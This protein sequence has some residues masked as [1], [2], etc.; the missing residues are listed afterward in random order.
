MRIRIRFGGGKRAVGDKSVELCHRSYC[1]D[2]RNVAG[3][4]AV[5]VAGYAKLLMY[6]GTG[7]GKM[8]AL[9]M[10]SRSYSLGVSGV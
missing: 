6:L 10:L 4:C 5:H 7:T 3:W 2:R 8:N 9:S 1:W